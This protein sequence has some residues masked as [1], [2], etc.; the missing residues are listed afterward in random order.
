MIRSFVLLAAFLAA[1][2]VLAE[3]FVFKNGVVVYEA[4]V[5][6]A[7]PSHVYDLDDEEYAAWATEENA[8]EQQR[9]LRAAAG[10]GGSGGGGS[11][12]FSDEN[13]SDNL[14]RQASF[15]RASSADTFGAYSDYMDKFHSRD[16]PGYSGA[17]L[18]I[19]NPYCRP[20]RPKRISRPLVAIINK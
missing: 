11:D 16:L 14:I 13:G 6:K 3:G 18:T 5:S 10:L 12:G 19:L 17:P 20:V 2:P 8:K 1:T 15:T 7:L 4:A 9:S